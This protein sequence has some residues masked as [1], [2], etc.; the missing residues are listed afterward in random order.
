[1]PLSFTAAKA[2]VSPDKPVIPG[3]KEHKEIL[4]LLK[5]SGRVFPQD[6][7]P[8]PTTFHHPSELRPR[9]TQYYPTTHIVSKREWLSVKANKEKYDKHIVEHQSYP[10]GYWQPEPNYLSWKGKT[11]TGASKRE[12][13]TSLK[14]NNPTSIYRNADD[15]G[16]QIQT[17]REA[18]GGTGTGEEDA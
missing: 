13:I 15:S 5:Q 18:Q 9:A 8:P 2:I 4:E 16:G 17:S 1:M 6:W 10:P 11:G 3:S 7:I 14:E 12:W